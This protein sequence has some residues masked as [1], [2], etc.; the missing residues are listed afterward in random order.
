VR[1]EETVYG[2]KNQQKVS[3]DGNKVT[4]NQSGNALCE[5]ATLGSLGKL[6]FAGSEFA[7]WKT[8]FKYDEVRL[9][10][11][12]LVSKKYGLKPSK[13]KPVGRHRYF[14]GEYD[15]SENPGEVAQV[16]TLMRLLCTQQ[17]S[18]I[19]FRDAVRVQIVKNKAEV[20]YFKANRLVQTQTKELK[21]AGCGQIPNLQKN[22]SLRLFEC[23][24]PKYG[25]LRIL[26][27]PRS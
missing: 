18:K 9:R 24:I 14:V 19:V 22:S 17:D 6:E 20:R 5:G 21:D 26:S 23:V 16:Q 3:F 11:L 8:K 12:G 25:T 15:V 10:N 4:L 27:E 7:S 13:P 1:V 2:F